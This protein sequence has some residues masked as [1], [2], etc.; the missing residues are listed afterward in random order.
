MGIGI[1]VNHTREDLSA[2]FRYPATSI[3]IEAGV[4]VKRQYVLTQFLHQFEKDYE[5]F[6]KKG[7]SAIL[8]EIEAAS[9]ILGKSVTVVC[10]DR[11]VRGKA[12]GFTPEGALILLAEDGRPE[13][14]WV[15]DVVRVE[16]A[17]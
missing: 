14:V 8:P 13:T 16:G 4:T 9:G 3:A 10:G 15:G 12:Q 6:L 2:P 17:Q 1:N 7:L 11:E 5:L